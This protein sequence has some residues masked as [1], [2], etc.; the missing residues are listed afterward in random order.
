MAVKKSKK[1]VSVSAVETAVKEDIMPPKKTKKTAP[2]D[3]QKLVS[4]AAFSDQQPSAAAPAKAK[5]KK[6]A[7]PKKEKASP[8]AKE[9]SSSYVV[10]D[11]PTEG[12]LVSGLAYVMRLGASSDGFVELSINGGDWTPC[13]HAAGYWWFDWGYYVPGPHKI[14]ARIVDAAGKVIKTS[15]VRKCTVI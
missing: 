2:V 9:T 7:A 12:E 13:R 4:E 6:P 14:T 8:A 10:I 3:I 5:A 11:Y 1:A 15:A